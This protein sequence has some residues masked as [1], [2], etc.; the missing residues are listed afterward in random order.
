M[1]KRV[2]GSVRT[3]KSL[4]ELI[5]GRLSCADGRG[6]LVKPATGL[7]IEEALEAE[8]RMLWSGTTTST[9]QPWARAGATGFGRGG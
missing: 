7:I 3:R 9:G 6:E 2:P 8:S 4:S 1:A 5:E